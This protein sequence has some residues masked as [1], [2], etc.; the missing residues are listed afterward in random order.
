[1]E[2]KFKKY[3]DKSF[4]SLGGTYFRYDT[5]TNEFGIINQY[6]GVSTYF[7]PDTKLN[8]WMEQISKNAPQN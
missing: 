6:G 3:T 5:A 1:M 8:Y 7:K 2:Y 4:V